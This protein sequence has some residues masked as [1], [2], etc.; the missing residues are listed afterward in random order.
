MFTMK[1]EYTP[2]FNPVQLEWVAGGR[3]CSPSARPPAAGRGAARSPRCPAGGAR[4]RRRRAAAPR[5]ARGP[6][7]ARGGAAA[8]QHLKRLVGESAT[9]SAKRQ[10]FLIFFQ[11]FFNAFCFLAPPCSSSFYVRTGVYCFLGCGGWEC[12]ASSLSASSRF[13][14]TSSRSGTL[15]QVPGVGELR[16]QLLEAHCSSTAWAAWAGPFPLPREPRGLPRA[17]LQ[18]E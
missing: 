16:A 9:E 1:H 4:A 13:E 15:A 11:C 18:A 7:P 10:R 8:H 5:R 3:V 2:A 12:R 17:N 14:E 6:G